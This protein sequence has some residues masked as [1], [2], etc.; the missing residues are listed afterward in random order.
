MSRRV[1]NGYTLEKI[2][3][4]DQIWKKNERFLINCQQ[5]AE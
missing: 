5:Q 4:D 1:L 2:R 3:T